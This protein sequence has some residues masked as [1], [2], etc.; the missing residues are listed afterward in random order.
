MLKLFPVWLVRAHST[1]FLYVYNKIS[2]DFQPISLSGAQ[3]EVPGSPC[4]LPAPALKLKT[5]VWKLGVLATAEV[6]RLLGSLSGQSRAVTHTHTHT[7]FHISISILASRS[8]LFTVFV[9]GLPHLLTL[10]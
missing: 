5:E 10:A 7:P 3:R 1:C 2:P 6:A 4:I 9:S 8:G